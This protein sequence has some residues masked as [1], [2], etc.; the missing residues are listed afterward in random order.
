MPWKR[1]TLRWTLDVILL[2]LV[3]AGG[4]L[5]FLTQTRGGSERVVEE[6]L[7]RLQD[8]IN[9]EIVVERVTSSRVLEG[10]TLQGVRIRGPTGALFF[11]AD[12]VRLE[13]APRTFLSGD[14]I[15]S[16][17][18]VW[19][20]TVVIR[21]EP[22][23]QEFNVDRVLKEREGEPGPSRTI[24]FRD[25]T[26][27]DSRVLV[28]YPIPEGEQPGP[29][30]VVI[31]TEDG[32]G[33]LRRLAFHRIEAGLPEVIVSSP[34]SPGPE[35]EVAFLSLVGRIYEDPFR[36]VGF[37][38][39]VGW[40][41][42]QLSVDFS[43]LRLPGT[44]ARGQVLVDFRPEEGP[45]VE[46]VLRASELALA[47]LQWLEPRLPRG[48]GRGEVELHMGPDGR[49]WRFADLDLTMEESRIAGDGVILEGGRRGLVFED[50]SLDLSPLALHRLEPFLAEPL[51]V[52]GTLRGRTS[53]SGTLDRLRA[54]GRLT[55]TTPDRAPSTAD[56]AGILHLDRPI[57]ATDLEA[58]LDPFDFGLAA[59]F[60]P[61]LEIRGPGRVELQATG[62][63]GQGI[64]F[65]ADVV[66]RPADLPRSHVVAS[67]T[68]RRSGEEVVLDVESDVQP[69]SF[70]ALR[71][72]Y[73]SLPMSG[74]V[75][76]RIA[77][78][79]PLSNLTITTDLDT[80]A[81]ELDV[82]ARLNARNPRAFYQVEGEVANFR[83]SQIVP[84]LPEPTVV[85]GYVFLEGRGTDAAT[86]RLTG[87]LRGH[88]S[89]VGNL[90]VDTVYTAVRVADGVLS[91]DTLD[92]VAGGVRVDAEGTLAVAEGEPSGEVRVAFESDSLA[93]L[94]PLFF[95]DEEIVTRD[96]LTDIDR[97][98]LEMEGTDPDT[99]PTEAEVA[100]GG[101]VRG[102]VTLRGSIR[103][104]SAEGEAT[105]EE[106]RYGTNYLRDAEV[107]F[108]AEH[109][110][111]LEGDFRARV[112]ADSLE[113]RNRAF[114]GADVELVYREPVGERPGGEFE[115][116]LERHED[117]DYRARA[118]FEVDTAGGVVHL[119]ELA[120]RFDTLRWE[121]MA[122]TS[123]AWTDRGLVVDDL[124]L[125]RTGVE[126][127]MSLRAE[128]TLPVDG[129]ADFTLEARD[130]SLERLARL[131][132]V[133]SA[134]RYGGVV[135]LDVRITGRADAP[136]MT[137]TVAARDLRYDDFVLDRVE[138]E[139]DYEARQVALDLD[140]WRDDLR[141]LVARGT[142]PVDLSFRQVA[143]RIPEEP[144]DLDVV[145][146]SLPAALG[147][148]F[149]DA[150]ED[151]EGTVAGEFHVGGTVEDP[152]PSGTLRLQNAAVTYPALGVRHTDIQGTLTLSPEG[153]VD[154]EARG[155]SGGGTAVVDGTL[156]L[157]PLTDPSF[158]SVRITL[159]E[160]R[161][162]N[163]SDV[164]GTVSGDM[165]LRGTYRRPFLEGTLT[166]D[167]GVLHV[168]EFQRSAQVVDLSDPAFFDVVD[169]TRI[170]APARLGAAQNPFLQ[171]LR[172][173]VDLRVERGTWLRSA[174]MNVEI[175]G[176][177]L[178]A[179][180]RGRG[181][182]RR[183]GDLVLVGE[184][185]AIR[186]SYSLY[187]RRFVVQEGTVEFVGTPGINPDLNIEAT[188]RIRQIDGEPLTI[189]ATVTGTLEDPRVVLSSP[190]SVVAQSDLVSYLI[191][192]RPT[193]ELASGE[194][195]VVE[196][197][198][199]R[200]VG[201]AAGA[202]LTLGFGTLTSRLGTLLGQE[203]EWL[204]YLAITQTQEFSLAGLGLGSTLA[205]T[206]IELGWYLSEDLFAVIVVRP[207]I[208]DG[209]TTGSKL[210]GVRLEWTAT[211]T[212][213]VEAFWE[214]RFLRRRTFG[215]GQLGVR[216]DKVLGFLLYR[217]WGY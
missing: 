150:F 172:M 171:N 202:G 52:R 19:R 72:Y 206:Q 89:R 197:A 57:G 132:Q 42:S 214:D 23:E 148:S 196:G 65:T 111:G 92:A 20:G 128:G 101:R 143:S 215:F 79:G 194:A 204:D 10:V 123:V 137:G 138:G 76:G 55:L 139:F 188:N 4:A 181:E 27:H 187:G 168:E 74:E 43:D 152:S 134:G 193:Y 130:L 124:R 125:A 162:V 62:R 144:I 108:S 126:E 95:G 93:P 49:R 116:F 208:D 141:V 180:D 38:G 118:T 103:D 117:E 136:V 167:E 210:G 158:E 114:S 15:L 39:D 94:R 182:D 40:A 6:V 78:R 30:E 140:A 163:R 207:L 185:E 98:R 142:V 31:P 192:G 2:V 200:L 73:P 47:D 24:L 186:G 48:Q 156:T 165:M 37:E 58:T 67:G 17:M 195:A 25:V 88:D 44:V 14:V 60:F 135:D 77:T 33:R 61:A 50:V 21:K 102:E 133:D 64:R 75:S 179:Y 190:E 45:V 70:T 90:F 3:V 191:F 199:G 96:D 83:L 85:N 212:Y 36:V 63:L 157:A 53:F 41:D 145:A 175:G 160:F 34:D 151:V 99:L 115:L 80:E 106:V 66:H 183:R 32:Q 82:V 189:T 120:L 198:A 8:A 170:S 18:T 7:R 131:A 112:V 81:G 164:E 9:G 113:I 51:P 29:R 203:F 69:L 5:Y 147:L 155:R 104:F 119:D 184:L 122:P 213:T 154:V 35:V 28:Y 169:T 201:T 91:L 110:P 1:K 86:L 87:R 166:V 127:G 121:L 26:L 211:D 11:S 68:V 178:V 205:G 12:S 100:F 173:A 107:A 174:D 105:F 177:L 97:R 71:R 13:Y 109:L 46:L 217:E 54:R 56:F 129:P 216:T 159:R 209:P 59:E 161:A 149:F 176:E 22:G 146:D 84:G 153:T 16:R